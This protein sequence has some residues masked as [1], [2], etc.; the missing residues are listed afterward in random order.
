MT[1]EW[2]SRLGPI[3]ENPLDLRGKIGDGRSGAG[4]NA[5]D[6]S[7]FSAR[8]LTA[9]SQRPR[10]NRR[11]WER[12]DPENGHKSVPFGAGTVFRTVRLMALRLY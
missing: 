12:E 10:R 4:T 7:G 5:T 3:R 8:L 11:D 6:L 2:G 9:E 1:V